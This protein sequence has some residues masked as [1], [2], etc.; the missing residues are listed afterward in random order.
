MM[1]LLSEVLACVKKLGTTYIVLDKLDQC[2][3]KFNVL[4]DKLVR[5][6]GDPSCDVKIAVMA[7]T[8]I[9]GGEWNLKYLPEGEYRLDHV[10]KRQAWNQ[11]KLTTLEMNR[12][13]RALTWTSESSTLTLVEETT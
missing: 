9:G 5:L 8:S 4:M 7:E 2:E 12:R 11:A 3:G 1:E 13:D 10:F 6:V